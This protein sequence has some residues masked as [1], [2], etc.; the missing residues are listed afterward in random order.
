MSI[1]FG[2]DG[3][4]AVIAEEF[5]FQNVGRVSQGIAGSVVVPSTYRLCAGE[6]GRSSDCTPQH[7][8]RRQVLL[9][10]WR[11]ASHTPV[12]RRAPDTGAPKPS[13]AT[14]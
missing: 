12:S 10:R 4:R 7:Y 8:G 14:A 13:R 5:T 1:P 3:W 6:C 9:R 2:T 11:L